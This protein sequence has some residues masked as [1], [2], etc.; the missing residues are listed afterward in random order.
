M[1]HI[2]SSL[3]P[4]V[5]LSHQGQDVCTCGPQVPSLESHISH[6]SRPVCCGLHGQLTIL[7]SEGLLLKLPSVRSWLVALGWSQPCRFAAAK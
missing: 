1:K 2:A 4:S 7:L 3:A 6:L 5:P